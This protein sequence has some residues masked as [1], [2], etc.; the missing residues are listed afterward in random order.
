MAL[1]TRRSFGVL[2]WEIMSRGSFPYPEL[3]DGEVVTAV[4]SQEYTL[5]Q[6]LDCPPTV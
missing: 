6:P 5:M 2:L 4:C 1:H 3:S